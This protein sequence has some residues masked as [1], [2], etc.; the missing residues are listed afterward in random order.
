MLCSPDKGPH[1][2]PW[3]MLI[4]FPSASSI[5][6]ADSISWLSVKV[7]D[8]S[9]LV[10]VNDRTGIK[11]WTDAFVGTEIYV[12][13]K[14]CD[15]NNKAIKRALKRGKISPRSLTHLTLISGPFPHLLLF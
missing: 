2:E 6:W 9:Y 7:Q 15:I 12:T 5:R 3:D 8:E 14:I 10:P 4:F 11:F 13:S 1:K